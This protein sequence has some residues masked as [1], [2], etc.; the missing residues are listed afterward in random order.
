M[1]VFAA[2][3]SAGLV[4]IAFAMPGERPIDLSVKALQLSVQ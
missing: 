2:L 4:A 1:L 3:A